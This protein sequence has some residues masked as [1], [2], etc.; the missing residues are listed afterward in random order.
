MAL[1]PLYSL[2]ARDLLGP[3]SPFSWIPSL[4][5]IVLLRHHS[6]FGQLASSSRLLAQFPG[7][8]HSK[9]KLKNLRLYHHHPAPTESKCL[10]SKKNSHTYTKTQTR[11]FILLV[12]S[13]LFSSFSFSFFGMFHGYYRLSTH[14]FYSSPPPIPFHLG[15]PV[16][17]FFF[18]H[19]F[20]SS[21]VQSCMNTKNTP[22]LTRACVRLCCC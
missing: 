16:V 15:N 12:F 1:Y 6:S 8:S 4:S 14:P 9:I 21:Q 22:C 7:T 13:F 17:F 3:R 19:P 5:S 11:R 20:P 2:F 18:T 10:M